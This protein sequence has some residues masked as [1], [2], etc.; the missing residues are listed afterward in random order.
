L[1]GT[2]T[3]LSDLSGAL[4]NYLITEKEYLTSTITLTVE[5]DNEVL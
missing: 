5:L 2:S 3:N 1:E 4:L